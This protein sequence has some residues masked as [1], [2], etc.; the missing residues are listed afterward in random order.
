MM[1]V[2]LFVVGIVLALESDGQC[3]SE[4]K[5]FQDLDAVKF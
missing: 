1:I 4:L 2:Y 3:S 5:A